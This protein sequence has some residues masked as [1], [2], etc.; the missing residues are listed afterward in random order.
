MPV[1]IACPVCGHLTMTIPTSPSLAFDL[2]CLAE[3]HRPVGVRLLSVR[4]LGGH[5]APCLIE[6][7]P[8]GACMLAWACSNRPDPSSNPVLDM[9]R[10]RVLAG[11]VEN[12]RKVLPDRLTRFR[13]KRLGKRPQFLVLVGCGFERLARLRRGQGKGIGS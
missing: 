2:Y 12:L 7:W 6:H 4:S 8:V 10:P 9:N 11:L 1:G 5:R 13:R 3:K